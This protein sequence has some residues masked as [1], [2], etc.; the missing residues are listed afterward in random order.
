M[1]VG[2]CG[3][4]FQGRIEPPE[5][6]RNVHDRVTVLYEQLKVRDRKKEATYLGRI[7]ELQ[8]EKQKKERL[9][10][11]PTGRIN[12]LENELREKDSAI[13]TLELEC[14]KVKKLVAVMVVVAVGW[15]LKLPL[16]QD[17]LCR[18]KTSQG[19]GHRHTSSL[20]TD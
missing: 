7:K 18:P 12:E 9:V 10:S 4:D 17:P 20:G 11:T 15:L 1:F 16:T 6:F 14:G 8:E 13:A 19:H 2:R 3:A 5:K